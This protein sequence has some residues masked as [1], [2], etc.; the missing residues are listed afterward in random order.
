VNGK[1]LEVKD[2]ETYTYLRLMTKDGETWAAVAKAPVQVGA[3]VTIE[4]VTIMQ[5]FESK[6]LKRNFDRIVFG[7]LVSSGT[8]AAAA[9]GDLAVLHAGV[10]NTLDVGDVKV[11]KATGPNARTV[12]E[13]ATRRTELKDKAVVVRGK[14]VKFTPAVL[15][16]NWIHLRDGSGSAS[17]G[18]ND[19]LVTT[20]DEA[21]I[22]DVVSVKGVVH[23][24]RDL[25]SGYSFKVLIDDATLQK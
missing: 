19:V 8:S 1:V 13:I 10:T 23:T 3:E 21:K 5:N 7:S 18:T 11:A 24:D 15:G 17:D 22:G 14:V 12:A 25:G 16:M 20:K 9:G 6:T 4:N 2:V